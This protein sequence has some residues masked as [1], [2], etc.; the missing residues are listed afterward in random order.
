MIAKRSPERKRQRRSEAD[1]LL[2]AH[3]NNRFFRERRD[4]H[5]T[6]RL[7]CESFGCATPIKPVTLESLFKNSEK[8]NRP[9]EEEKEADEGSNRASSVSTVGHSQLRPIVCEIAIASRH[10]P[11][12][13]VPLLES[14]PPRV[15]FAA[16]LAFPERQRTK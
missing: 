10:V 4:V 3:K 13:A 6:S 15:R 9:H 2:E 7:L 8:G 16:L 14:L 11:D 1:R 5:D 12:D